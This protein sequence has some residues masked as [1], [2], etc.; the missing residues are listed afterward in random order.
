MLETKF[1]IR[2][3]TV[4]LGEHFTNVE[5]LGVG[6]K[7]LAMALA[8]LVKASESDSLRGGR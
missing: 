6:E 1:F 5:A 2:M 8:A 4:L 7:A 3:S